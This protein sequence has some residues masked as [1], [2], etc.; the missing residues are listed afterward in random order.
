MKQLYTVSRANP[1]IFR[2]YPEGAHNNTVAAPGYFQHIA[3]FI[4]E[5]VL[6]EPD[7]NS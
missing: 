1:K 6:K 4:E 5:Y 2:S 7:S 3:D